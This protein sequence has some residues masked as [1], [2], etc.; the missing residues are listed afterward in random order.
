MI[1]AIVGNVCLNFVQAIYR[2]KYIHMLSEA[3][4]KNVY[5]YFV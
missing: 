3:Y 1:E 5:L 4:I 2:R